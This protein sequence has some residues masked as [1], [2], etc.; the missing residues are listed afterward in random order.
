MDRSDRFD[1]EA[2]GAAEAEPTA[3]VAPQEDDRQAPLIG[4]F[5]ELSFLTDLQCRILVTAWIH[6]DLVRAVRAAESGVEVGPQRFD[7]AGAVEAATGLLQTGYLER[8]P[9]GHLAL[10]ARG[11]RL[12]ETAAQSARTMHL[13]DDPRGH[14]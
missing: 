7:G 11:R 9:Q 13:A 6:G 5:H 1:R 4:G 14:A 12:A 3:H 8:R 10:T 2:G